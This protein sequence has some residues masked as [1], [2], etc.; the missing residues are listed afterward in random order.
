MCHIVLRHFPFTFRNPGLGPQDWWNT[1]G[2]CPTSLVEQNTNCNTLENEPKWWNT[3]GPIV[4][5]HSRFFNTF[6]NPG[7]GPQDWWDT[8]GPIVFQQS[9]WADHKLRNV[10][11]KSKNGG[12]QWPPLCSTFF[13][14][15]TCVAIRMLAHKIGAAQWA[16]LC[17]SNLAEQDTNCETIKNKQG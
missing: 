5:H 16:P 2:L 14:C 10:S 17:T 11:K 6:R 9:C 8:M 1:M 15:L 4:F 7:Y 12:T 3:M 13:V